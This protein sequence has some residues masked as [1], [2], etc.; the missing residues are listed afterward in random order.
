MPAIDLACVFSSINSEVKLLFDKKGNGAVQKISAAVT[1][2]SGK[3]GFYETAS[4]LTRQRLQF[5]FFSVCTMCCRKISYILLEGLLLCK[6]AKLVI[7]LLTVTHP[8]RGLVL[9]VLFMKTMK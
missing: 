6:P 1:Q 5:V 2:T 8:F 7:F 4:Q 3:I 9:C